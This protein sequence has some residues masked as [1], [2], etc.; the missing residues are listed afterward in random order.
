[1]LLVNPILAPDVIL[2][3]TDISAAKEVFD[4]INKNRV[5]LQPWFPWVKYTQEVMDSIVF[6][7]NCRQRAEK[8]DVLTFFIKVKDKIIGLIDIH[9]LQVEDEIPQIGYWVDADYEGKGYVSQAMQLLLDFYFKTYIDKEIIAIHC[10]VENLRSKQV[11]IRAGFA[12]ERM[13]TTIIDGSLEKID[14]YV[15]PFKNYQRVL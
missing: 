2:E 9:K 15:L 14:V 13:T 6:L 10:A 8:G 4:L 7:Q 5:H 12:Y 11:A 3:P 1:M